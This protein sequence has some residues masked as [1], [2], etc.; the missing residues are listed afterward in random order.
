MCNLFD[1]ASE[2]KAIALLNSRALMTLKF[3][4]IYIKFEIIIVLMNILY[5]SGVFIWRLISL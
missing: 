5:G 1:K 3:S 4:C 2:S